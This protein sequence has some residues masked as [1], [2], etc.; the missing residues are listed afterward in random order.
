[1]SDPLDSLHPSYSDYDSYRGPPSTGIRIPGPATASG[2]LPNVND[3]LPPGV[4]AFD[5][6]FPARRSATPELQYPAED[7]LRAVTPPPR[8]TTLELHFV[9]SPEGPALSPLLALAH[10]ASIARPASAPP[11]SYDEDI[12]ILAP[13]RPASALACP[14]PLDVAQ[15]QEEETPTEFTFGPPSRSAP[16][17]Y[18]RSTEPSP[19]RSH[20]PFVEPPTP[21]EPT[22]LTYPSVPRVDR[23]YRESR[24]L[25]PLPQIIPV[26]LVQPN[27]QPITGPEYRPSP[28][29]E[30]HQVARPSEGLFCGFLEEIYIS[31]VLPTRTPRELRHFQQHC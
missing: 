4:T 2:V 9:D 10:I 19:N 15:P 17:Y 13:N 23:F 30:V 14:D 22:Q 7:V 31:S 11:I 3:I 29:E 8:T 1:V 18:N 25:P 6:L 20:T 5:Y 16:R 28:Q 21:L 24:P 27:Q 12:E 26:P